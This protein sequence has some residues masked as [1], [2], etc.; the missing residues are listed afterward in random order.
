MKSFEPLQAI[1]GGPDGLNFYRRLIPKTV[2]WLK[3]R[4]HLILEI[5][6]NQWP[7]VSEM[8][9]EYFECVDF[10]SDYANKPRAVF[11]KK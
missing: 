1:D 3:S 11:A 7:A 6:D 9:S 2:D 4:G 10:V 5:G 8:L